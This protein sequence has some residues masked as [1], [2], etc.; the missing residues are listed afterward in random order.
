MSLHGAMVRCSI[1]LAVLAGGL[2]LGGPLGAQTIGGYERGR[3]RDMLRVVRER[4]ER[5]YYDST[6]HG[7]DLRAAAARADSQIQAAQS[8][9]QIFR[10]IAEFVHALDDSHTWFIPPRRAADVKYGW[11]IQMIGDSCYVVWVEPESDAAAKGLMVGDRRDRP[12]PAPTLPPRLFSA[13]IRARYAQP[14]T[15]PCTSEI[16]AADGSQRTLDIQAQKV[17]ERPRMTDLSTIIRE[18][19]L[20]ERQPFAEFAEKG[21]EVLILRLGWFGDRSDIDR[22][23][24]R[25]RKVGTVILDLRGNPGGLEDGLV[26]LVGRVFDRRL[27][28]GTIRRRRDTR[29]LESK[30]VGHPFTGSLF[31]LIDSRSSSS[32][33]IFA[34]LVQLEGARRRGGRPQRRGG[35]AQQDSR[36]GYGDECPERLWPVDHKCGHDYAGRHSPGRTRRAA[37]R[38]RA[39]HRRRSGRGSR[40][41]AGHGVDDGRVPDGRGTGRHAAAAA[42][43]EPVMLSTSLMSGSRSSPTPVPFR[44]S[45]RLSGRAHYRGGQLAPRGAKDES[46]SCHVSDVGAPRSAADQGIAPTS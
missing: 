16:E 6:F 17:T 24:G 11:E 41:G 37:G 23:M 1:T 3:G 13:A 19:E 36:P 21:E 5:D 2:P 30:P 33:E 43:R 12:G 44:R 39:A 14:E 26:R 15:L 40:P 10:V 31:V 22:A 8:N 28:I 35:H 27:T 29:A 7:I 42:R 4:L 46:K 32:S 38:A 34:Q 18:L 45:P 25:A 9:S 20:S